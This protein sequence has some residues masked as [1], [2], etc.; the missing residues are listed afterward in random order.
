MGSDGR[1]S[2]GS[3]GRCGLCV[4]LNR[5]IVSIAMSVPEEGQ[6]LQQASECS[7]RVF[8][9]AAL[10]D[11]QV[12]PIEAALRRER[13][14]ML[15]MGTGA[16]KSLCFQLAAIMT[17]ERLG[18]GTTLVV[19]P[20]KTIIDDQVDGLAGRVQVGVLHG[21]VDW[22]VKDRLLIDVISRDEGPPLVYTTTDSFMSLL[23]DHT[24]RL[25]I[26]GRLH[27]VVLDEV[28]EILLACDYRPVMVGQDLILTCDGC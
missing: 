18:R 16:G 10:R 6:L 9:I 26:L 14:L 3:H 11:Y 17:R 27:R 20:S 5:Y 13:F 4:V 21:D 7:Q 1:R 23:K 19:L 25:A 8:G 24:D 12:P 2:T 22:I 15:S 28:H